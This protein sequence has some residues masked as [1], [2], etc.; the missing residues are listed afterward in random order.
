[1]YYVYVLRSEKTGRFY[2]GSC[3]DLEDRLR[4]HHAGQSLA[5]RHGGPWRLVYQEGFA[6]RA[7][8]MRRERE[9]K[10][11]RGRDELRRMLG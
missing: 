4:R 1:M 9:L 11:G 7:E 10:T 5:T 6:S 8:A 2:T 3:A